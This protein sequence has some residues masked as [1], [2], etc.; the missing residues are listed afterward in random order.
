MAQF[1]DRRPTARYRG[2]PELGRAGPTGVDR[3]HAAPQGHA[4][5][6]G[7]L[8]EALGGDAGVGRLHPPGQ[9]GG[10]GG[11][12]HAP[13]AMGVAAG[14][15]DALQPDRAAGSSAA[16]RQSGD[17]VAPVAAR[18]PPLT[19]TTSGPSST[20]ARAAASMSARVRTGKPDQGLGLGQVGR[21]HRRQGQQQGADGVDRVGAPAAGRR[22]STPAPGRPPGGRRRARPRWWPPPRRSRPT[23]ASPSWPRRR[24]GRRPPRRSGPAPARASPR[25]RPGRRACSGR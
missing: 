14:Q 3:A 24:R 2:P 23:P 18:W 10:D 6:D 20:R 4:A 12:E 17:A 21:E 19:S 1:L 9:L 8:D 13:G 5:G 7:P 11:R 22:A 15:P 25:R 16:S